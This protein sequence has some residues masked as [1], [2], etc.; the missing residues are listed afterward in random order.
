MSA[1]LFNPR[2]KVSW[3]EWLSLMPKAYGTNQ[4][5]PEA[6]PVTTGITPESFEIIAKK[7]VSSQQIVRKD[8]EIATLRDYIESKGG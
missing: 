2:S 3:G 5:E 8:T 4:V 6:V 1:N 7:E